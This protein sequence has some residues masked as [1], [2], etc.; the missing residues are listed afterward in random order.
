M[1]TSPCR[2][3]G[4]VRRFSAKWCKSTK[5]CPFKL[6][7]SR[8]T[9]NSW[10][11]PCATFTTLGSSRTLFRKGGN[12]ENSVTR[13]MQAT[14]S[15]ASCM[16]AVR[17]F[18]PKAEEG[19]LSE[20]K[21]RSFSPANKLSTLSSSSRLLMTT[22]RLEKFKTGSR[23]ISKSDIVSE[24]NAGGG[25][26]DDDDE[27]DEE[28]E[29][30]EMVEPEDAARIEASRGGCCRRRLNSEATAGNAGRQPK[31]VSEKWRIDIVVDAEEEEGNDDDDEEE[32]VEIERGPRC[33]GALA[34]AERAASKRSVA[35]A[36]ICEYQ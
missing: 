7:S 32:E 4:E 17:F 23:A 16:I 3:R 25:V 11:A 20:S 21:P 26:G 14:C 31:A 30:E 18:G 33:Q 36:I 9:A 6:Y 34:A 22:I 2:D 13:Q 35:A 27:D 12:S 19:R 24:G 5:D 29:M 28:D 10:E 15:E 8:R 1:P